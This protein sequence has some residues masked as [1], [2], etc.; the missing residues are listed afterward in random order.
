M[1]TQAISDNSLNKKDNQGLSY[2]G[3]GNSY[4]D[5]RR[6]ERQETLREFLQ[7]QK[8]IELIHQTLDATIT[9][10]ELPVIKFKTETRLKLLN[11]VLPDLKA[12]EMS[13]DENNPLTI[14]LI[15][16]VIVDPY[17]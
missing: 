4:A 12:V 9:N 15:E 8:Y 3:Q 14:R 7:G 10:D 11:K 13:S 5:K 16:R 1:T 17:K 2:T 6:H